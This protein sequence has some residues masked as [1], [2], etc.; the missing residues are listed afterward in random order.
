MSVNENIIEI[1]LTSL[2]RG[3]SSTTFTGRPQGMELRAS[4]NLDTL[5]KDELK[6]MIVIPQGTTSINPSFYLGLFFPSYKNLE[7]LDSFKKKYS[8]VFEDTNV[9]LTEL[10]KDSLLDCEREANNEFLGK[11][12][13]D[14][15]I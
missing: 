15:I 8:V 2:H 6:Y 9:V 3:K 4:L 14:S 5:D 10:L 13:L 7:G 11:T 12:G 1:K